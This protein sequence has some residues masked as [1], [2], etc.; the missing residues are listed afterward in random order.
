MSTSPLKDLK[1]QFV[2]LSLFPKNKV[3]S[4][5]YLVNIK[6]WQI[7]AAIDRFLY[8]NWKQSSMDRSFKNCYEI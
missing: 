2:I 4:G 8:N 3:F 1:V 5:R 6:L 7:L